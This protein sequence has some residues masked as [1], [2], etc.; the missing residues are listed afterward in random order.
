MA[1]TET[2]RPDRQ[3]CL[4]AINIGV[5]G[6]R[7]SDGLIPEELKRWFVQSVRKLEA[8]A[9]AREDCR[10]GSNN[11]CLDLL[12]GDLSIYPFIVNRTRVRSEVV[13]PPLVFIVAGKVIDLTPAPKSS[14]VDSTFNLKKHL[15]LPTD[16]DVSLDGKVKAKSYIN[17]LN[18]IEHKDKY[19]T[20]E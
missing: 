13:I 3:E 20:L 9:D 1:C 12:I 14:A 19:L 17:N 2:L 10:L 6:T 5:Q 11:K 4:M 15:W 7:Q 8:V 18:P 16:F